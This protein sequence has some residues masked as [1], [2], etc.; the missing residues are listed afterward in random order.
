MPGLRL[1]L[2]LGAIVEQID[3]HKAQRSQHRPAEA[4]QVVSQWGTA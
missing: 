3:Q 4:V 1:I 2:T